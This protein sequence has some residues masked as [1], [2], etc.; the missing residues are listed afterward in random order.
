M[1]IVQ[2]YA[3]P[4]PQ[5][6]GS[7]GISRYNT[8][9]HFVV[10]GADSLVLTSSTGETW[11]VTGTNQKYINNLPQSKGEYS[12]REY[13][14]TASKGGETVTKT[15]KVFVGNCKYPTNEWYTRI[16]NLEPSRIYTHRL[17]KIYG[18]D[19]K[20]LASTLQP[21]VLFSNSPSSSYENPQIFNNGDDVYVQVKSL[22]FNTDISGLSDTDQFGKTNEKIV[23]ILIGSKELN[24][25]V[26]TRAPRIREKFNYNNETFGGESLSNN[27]PL[28]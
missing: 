26:V 28:P 1:E 11:D 14:L 17:G 2:F 4:N 20:I 8:T 10:V 23:P 3:S 15:I 24:I 13:T 22:P 6:S 25:S 5:K 18:V 19:M 7:D 12:S 9:L 27:Q 16:D 21:D